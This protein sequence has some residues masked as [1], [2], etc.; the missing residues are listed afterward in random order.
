M[1]LA[2][3]INDVEKLYEYGERLNEAK[4]KSKHESDYIGIIAAAKGSSK[5]KQLAAQLIPRFFKHFPG[6]S[7]E[8]INAHFDLC[9]EDELGACIDL[10]VLLY[11]QRLAASFGVIC[12]IPMFLCVRVHASPVALSSVSTLLDTEIRHIASS[13]V[14]PLLA[15]LPPVSSPNRCVTLYWSINHACHG[16]SNIQIRVQAIR[17]LPLLCRDTPEHVPKIVDVL[18]QLLL[19]EENLERD[20]VQKALMSFLRQDT[21]GDVFL[22]YNS[23][24]NKQ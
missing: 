4:D 5:A 13:R 17:G 21:K 22:Y 8:A 6:L 20:A 7:A 19:A 15:I 16:A 18:G 9:E 3:E 24:C 12:L 10:E 2:E 14:C 11:W 23:N 1:A